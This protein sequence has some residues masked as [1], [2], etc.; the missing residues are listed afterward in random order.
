MRPQ[1]STGLQ[2]IHHKPPK[3]RYDAAA[4]AAG[5]TLVSACGFDS[6]PADLG[7]R[8][9]AAMFPPGVTPC[10]IE[11]YLT[12][13]SRAC[14][15]AAAAAAPSLILGMRALQ[16]ARRLWATTRRTERRLFSGEESD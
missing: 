14:W 11:S 1:G 10:Y 6:V 9:V 3:L 5:L 7:A 12:V 15:F 8:V 2:I 4:R 13:D 16:T